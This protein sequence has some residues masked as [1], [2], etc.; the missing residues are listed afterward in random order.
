MLGLYRSKRAWPPLIVLAA[1]TG[2]AALLNI[3]L[4]PMMGIAGAALA[5]ALA[6][7]VQVVLS[8]WWSNR[9]WSIRL[10]VR[11]LLIA[12]PMSLALSWC[13]YR[14]STGWYAPLVLL[15]VGGAFAWLMQGGML[16]GLLRPSGNDEAS[17]EEKVAATES[18]SLHHDV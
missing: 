14:I 11:A 2:V 18:A 5:F 16:Q 7:T 4:I 15:A 10:P 1:S 3:S 17:A 9:Y 6:K 8:W 12:L 13:A